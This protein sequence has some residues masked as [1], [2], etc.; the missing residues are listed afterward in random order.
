MARKGR[1]GFDPSNTTPDGHYIVGKG[2][3]PDHGKFKKG[4]GRQ[5][6]R[7]PKQTKNLASD[8]R[9]E[10]QSSVAVT[11]GGV[12][13]KVTR[14]RAVVMRMADNATKGQTSA[15]AL[16]LELQQRLVDPITQQEDQRRER[17]RDYSC[18]SN[19]ELNVMLYLTAKVEHVED[20]ESKIVGLIP[21]YDDGRYLTA[22]MH[23]AISAGLRA[24]GVEIDGSVTF[25]PRCRLSSN[26]SGAEE[27]LDPK[28]RF[29]G[30]NAHRS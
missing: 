11:V 8:L 5:R 14:Q 19:L 4:D 2:R 3:P 25:P 13:K 26:H 20:V 17:E 15:I 6:G 16:L 28:P 9:E 23:E 29:A 21:I 7:R 18:L 30:K 24:Y 12:A 10:L 1:F 22:E 27:W